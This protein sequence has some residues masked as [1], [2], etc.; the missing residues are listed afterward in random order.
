MKV[1]RRHR[2]T[3]N[4]LIHLY[5]PWI[6]DCC[7]LQ[8]KDRSTRSSIVVNTNERKSIKSHCQQKKR[9]LYDPPP[10]VISTKKKRENND[11][12]FCD[13]VMAQ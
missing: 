6:F 9:R 3:V 4:S 1:N 2:P 7:L 10:T 8:L 13:L 5:G 11:F 12:L